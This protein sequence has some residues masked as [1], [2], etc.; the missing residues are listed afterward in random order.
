MVR[1]LK[2]AE[3]MA[4]AAALH[5]AS[6]LREKLEKQ[7]NVRLLSATGT[8]QILFLE[9]LTSQDGIDW[10][11][12]ELFHLDEYVGIGPD[13]PAS[14]A[15]YTRERLV[16]PT[17]IQIAHLMD[18]SRDP[19]AVAAEISESIRS[20]PIDLALVGI[21]ENGH[22]AFN[23]PPADFETAEAYM[24]VQLDEVC[25][26]QQVGE[27]WFRSIEEVP[28]EAITI[29]IPQLL[30]SKEIICVVPDRRKAEAVKACLD[31]PVSHAAPASALRLH[32][33]ASI[34]LDSEAASLLGQ[35][36]S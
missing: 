33:H 36:S 25:R 15:R 11:R 22:L 23:D 8:S 16:K 19:R 35:R 21:G 5:A 30:R 26:K 13:H 3:E 17:G 14:F 2:T 7:K 27:G 18:G 31:G 20:A 1:I 34:Y 6:S 9:R 4:Q 32:P 28:R 24:V 12:V 29:S 10:G